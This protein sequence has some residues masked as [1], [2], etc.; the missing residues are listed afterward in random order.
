MTDVKDLKTI[1]Y[2]LITCEITLD[3]YFC[4]GP[5]VCFLGSRILILLAKL[6]E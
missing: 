4:P 6:Y 2:K 1:I 5:S 3:K